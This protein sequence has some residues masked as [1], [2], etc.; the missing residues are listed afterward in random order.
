M[1]FSPLFAFLTAACSIPAWAA[2]VVAVG[3]AAAGEKKAAVCAACHGMDGNATDPQ[4]PNLA[5]QHEAY[6]ATQLAHF[7]SGVRENAIMVAFAAPLS[8]QDMLD[9]GAFFAKQARKPGLADDA[10]LDAGQRLYRGG[11]AARAIPA[12]MAC[13]GP[14]GRGNPVTGYPAVAGQHAQYTAGMLKRF[15]DGAAFGAPDDA[16]A[17]IM[18]QIAAKLTDQDIE[19]LASTLQGLHSASP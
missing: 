12:C 15:R 2:D 1:K 16:Q 14:D 10:Y 9:I 18:A 5:G 17:K 4:Y 6:I 11:D 3:D 19:A 7:K 8:E 13:H